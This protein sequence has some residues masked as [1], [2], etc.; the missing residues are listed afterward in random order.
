MKQKR[1]ST[2]PKALQA[3]IHFCLALGA[4]VFPSIHAA[5]GTWT[6]TTDG[7]WGDAGNWLGSTVAGGA[8]SEASFTLSSPNNITVALESSR[9][10]GRLNFHDADWSVIPQGFWHLSN[11]GNAANVLTLDGLAATPVISVKGAGNADLSAAIAGS[12]GFTKI[13]NGNLFLS[14]ANLYTGTTTIQQGRIVLFG[15]GT[16]GNGADL[17]IGSDTPAGYGGSLDLG[18]STQ[19]VGAVEI[20]A[21]SEKIINGNLIGSSYSIHNS[22]VDGSGNMGIASIISAGLGGTADF[23]KTGAGTTIL[24]GTNTHTGTTTVSGG[25]LAISGAGTLGN[26]NALTV[27][28]SATLDLGGTSQPPFPRPQ[29]RPNG[30]FRGLPPKINS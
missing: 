5:D 21:T 3:Y 27:H 14:G 30:C 12:A 13:G 17:V 23:L 11:G 8:G 4:C 6:S 10:I 15:D 25:T 20:S 24:S 18:G 9:T 2:T 26:Q 28:D 7:S 22:G 29:V 19:T 1:I 16:L